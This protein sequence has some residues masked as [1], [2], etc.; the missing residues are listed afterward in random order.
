MKPILNQLV[1]RHFPAEHV[2]FAFGYGSAVF[3]Q[4]NYDQSNKEQVID[5][6]LIVD[7]TYKF[8]EKNMSMNYN[9]YSSWP[10]RLTLSFT[11]DIQNRGS[12]LYFNP[13]IPLNTFQGVTQEGDQRRIKYGIVSEENAI[14]D[15]LSWSS[16]ALAGRLQKPVLPFIKESPQCEDAL[17]SNIRNALNVGI[18]LNYHKL[19]LTLLD[20]F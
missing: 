16:F 9:H 3:K 1:T 12:N 6:I 11:N 10:K 4:A 18:L 5:M 19:D 14:K 7:D 8:H 13:L 17:Q 15:L 20:L 2:K